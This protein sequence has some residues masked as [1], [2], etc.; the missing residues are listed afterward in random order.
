METNL[1]LG[2]VG[3][4]HC[5]LK[6]QG[7]ILS[8]GNFLCGVLHVHLDFLWVPGFPPSSPIHASWWIGNEIHLGVNRCVQGTLLGV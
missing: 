5:H 8:L 1:V 7:S 2:A 6:L 3:L 4:A